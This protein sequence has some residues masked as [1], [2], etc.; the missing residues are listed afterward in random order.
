MKNQILTRGN[1]IILATLLISAGL[2]GCGGPIPDDIAAFLK[3]YEVNT[4]TNAYFLQPPD[5]VEIYCAK[6]PEI[7]Q[8]KQQIRP[9]GRISFPKLGEI[10]V[11]GK[12]P[13]MVAK[14]IEA[15]VTK[16]YSLTGENPVDVRVARF[17]SQFYYVYG[18]VRRDG[19]MN[20]TGRDTVLHAVAMASP[21]YTAWKKRIKVIRPSAGVKIDPES[22][23]SIVDAKTFEI[24]LEE[25]AQNGD[26]SRNVLLQAGDIIYVPPTPLAKVSYVL[27][28]FLKPI[29]QALSPVMQYYQV[30]RMMNYDRDY[31]RR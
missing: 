17:N 5:E 24:N 13:A 11:A 25:M 22:A 20:Y 16:L 14:D 8:Q 27:A 1:V 29:G 26:A 6:V 30:D 19:P 12:T 21:T 18:E 2:T 28:E 23:I 4:T 9:D 10:E 15:R 3:P 7:H 31:G